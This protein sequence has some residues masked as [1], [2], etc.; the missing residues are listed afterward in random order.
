MTR[1]VTVSSKSFRTALNLPLEDLQKSYVTA[2][3]YGLKDHTE[4]AL[5]IFF[6]TKRQL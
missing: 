4:M 2:C 1:N 6:A 3:S 5:G